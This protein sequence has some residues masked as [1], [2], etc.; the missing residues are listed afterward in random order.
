VA[1]AELIAALEREADGEVAALLAQAGAEAEA[2]LADA[3]TAAARRCEHALAIE[4][5]RLAREEEAAIAAAATAARAE[6]LVARERVLSRAAAATRSAA[7][8]AE[9]ALPPSAIC[10]LV[11]A[12]RRYL[13]EGAVTLRCP[14]ALLASAR[15]AAADLA[16]AV[17]P[18]EEGEGLA[19]VAGAWRVELGLPALVE[20]R[21]PALAPLVLLALLEGADAETR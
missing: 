16:I 21:W 5:H 20:R 9:P 15:D 7:G 19:L 17:E 13:A 6:E 14:P 11:A 10:R 18:A 3:D 4:Q 12:G 8:E 2:I 1:L